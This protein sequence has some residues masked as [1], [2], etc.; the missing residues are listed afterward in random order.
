MLKESSFFAAPR[1][2]GTCVFENWGVIQVPAPEPRES[3]IMEGLRG[4]MFQNR[5]ASVPRT[6]SRSVSV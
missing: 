6:S 2:R 3:L 4:R 1:S 5:K